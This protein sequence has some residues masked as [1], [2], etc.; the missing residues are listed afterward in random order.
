MMK[1][2]YQVNGEFV[3]MIVQILPFLWRF[4]IGDGRWRFSFNEDRVQ[5]L[6]EIA[7]DNAIREANFNT[8]A[9]TYCEAD[10]KATAALY[11][12]MFHG[13]KA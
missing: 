7:V 12:E 2:K 8:F 10:V 9:S 1:T 13:K 5:R 3:Y 4:K 11:E 6:C